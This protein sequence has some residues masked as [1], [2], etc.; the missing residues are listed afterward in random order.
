MTL[1]FSLW[2]TDPF[3]SW[4][5]VPPAI[6]LQDSRQ[7]R[8]QAG[9]EASSF[10]CPPQDCYVRQKAMTAAATEPQEMTRWKDAPISVGNC[11]TSR[12][13]SHERYSH[14]H[15]RSHYLQ[16]GISCVAERTFTL[17]LSSISVCLFV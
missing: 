10:P 12:L 9:E 2:L 15:F 1:C 4:S 3:V 8:Q 6:S 14:V 11:H 13:G 17:Y 7:S 16:V 5:T